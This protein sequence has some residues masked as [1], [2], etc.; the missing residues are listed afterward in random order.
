MDLLQWRDQYPHPKL[1]VVSISSADKNQHPEYDMGL[2]PPAVKLFVLPYE[3]QYN[4][5]HNCNDEV[6]RKYLFSFIGRSVDQGKWQTRQKI[7]NLHNGEDIFAM[8]RWTFMKEFPEM[9]FNEIMMQSIF[10]G[11]P[12]GDN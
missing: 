3:R 12:G 7:T 9:S 6:L 4:I 11:A 2:P 8:H 10:S 1:S 5:L